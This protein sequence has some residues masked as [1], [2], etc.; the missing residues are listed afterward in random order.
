MDSFII[1]PHFKV[2]VRIQPDYDIL[3]SNDEI[4]LDQSPFYERLI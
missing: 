1:S 2:Q 4:I 3:E